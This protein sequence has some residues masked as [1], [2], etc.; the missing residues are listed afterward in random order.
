LTQDAPFFPYMIRHRVKD[1]EKQGINP[2]WWVQHQSYAKGDSQISELC[3]AN[4]WVAGNLANFLRLPVPPFALFRAAGR[5][6]I[7]TEWSQSF[8]DSIFVV[9]ESR[10]PRQHEEFLR[11]W[12]PFHAFFFSGAPD[13]VSAYEMGK[14]REHTAFKRLEETAPP[15]SD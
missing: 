15:S 3:I 10:T 7:E 14:L 4:E 2:A 9:S 12:I 11:E 8:H 1:E 6:V 13:I 5:I